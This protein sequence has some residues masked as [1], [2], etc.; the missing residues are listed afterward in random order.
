MIR[1]KELLSEIPKKKWTNVEPMK[2]ADDLITIVQQAYKKAPEGSFIRSKRDL[3][4]SDWH[5][6]DIDDKPDIDATIFYRTARAGE[7]WQG[8]KIQGIGHDGSRESIDAVLNRLKLLLTKKGNWVEASDAL[9]HILYKMGVRYISDEGEA[10]KVFPN[11]NLKM[12]GD[13][14]K[15]VR[16][17]GGGKK[18]KE[19]IF[20]FPK[21]S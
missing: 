17:L 3:A 20:G 8:Q 21:I 14:G 15:Y 4:G 1:L 2:Y 18:I 19:T 16:E 6:I 7:P 5:S 10:Q 11:S 9:E 13:R 12:T